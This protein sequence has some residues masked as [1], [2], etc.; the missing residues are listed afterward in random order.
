[1]SRP[2]QVELPIRLDQIL[3]LSGLVETGGQAKAA[4]QEGMVRV[5]GT[6]ETRRGRQLRGGEVITFQQKN[7]VVPK[8][9]TPRSPA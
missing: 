9:S 5:D 6:V 8:E 7:V 2:L 1:M 4:V 3:Q